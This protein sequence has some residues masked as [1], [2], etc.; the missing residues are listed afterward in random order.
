MNRNN[1]KPGQFEKMI[2]EGRNHLKF[3]AALYQIQM[4]QGRYFLHEHPWSASS[5]KEPCIQSLVQDPRV[6]V[7]KGDMCCFGMYQNVG[8]EEMFVKKSTGFMTNACEVA[9]VLSETCENQHRHVHL[10]NGRA[11]RAEVYPDELCYRIMIG[12]LNQ[13][14][15]DGRIPEFGIGAIWPDDENQQM[16]GEAYDDVTGEEL[17]YEG[18]IAARAEEVEEVHKHQVFKYAPIQ[19]RWDV[20]GK[21]P[22]KIRWLDINKG[23]KLH[24]EYRSRWVAKDFND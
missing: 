6:N 11:S 22:K 13:M 18:V 5:W 24:P 1:M 23:D 10:L 16:T 4:D 14:K 3:C 21:A 20:T 8:T 15:R 17:D 7:V 12:I 9:K 19:E 2:E